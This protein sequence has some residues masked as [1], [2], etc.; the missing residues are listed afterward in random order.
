MCIHDGAPADISC[1]AGACIFARDTSNKRGIPLPRGAHIRDI[2]LLSFCTTQRRKKDEREQFFHCPLRKA[3]LCLQHP[4]FPS[5]HMSKWRTPFFKEH[6][7]QTECTPGVEPIQRPVDINTFLKFVY[8]VSTRHFSYFASPRLKI[9]ATVE[10][11]EKDL[12]FRKK[13]LA[14]KG[15]VEEA[16]EDHFYKR[17]S[18]SL[19]IR[20]MYYV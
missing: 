10:M 18:V 16:G 19:F 7:R 9:S 4:Q 13:C 12:S 1:I 20:H 8:G 6:V 14:V 15:H 5:W 17:L 3:G 11:Y 2:F